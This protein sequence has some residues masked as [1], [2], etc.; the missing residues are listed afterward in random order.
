MKEEIEEELNFLRDLKGL[1]N[2]HG[3]E[4]GSDTPDYI[5]AIFLERCLNAFDSAVYS[6][7]NQ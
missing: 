2:K 4:S 6:R 1:I 5:L 7:T 3:M